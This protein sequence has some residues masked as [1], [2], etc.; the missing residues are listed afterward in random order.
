MSV[1]RVVAKP[2]HLRNVII[3]L[4]D[5]EIFWPFVNNVMYEC[6]GTTTTRSMDR[7]SGLYGSGIR[8]HANRVHATNLG[9][10]RERRRLPPHEHLLET[11]D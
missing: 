2:W 5:E 10:V 9:N 1:T 7:H 8:V 6:V 11:G 4:I 3:F